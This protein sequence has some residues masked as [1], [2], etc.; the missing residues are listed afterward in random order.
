MNSTS[1]KPALLF[2]FFSKHEL[3][4]AGIF[5]N[6]FPQE[7]HG[8]HQMTADMRDVE[9]GSGHEAGAAAD[10]MDRRRTMKDYTSLW[11]LSQACVTALFTFSCSPP[12]S[13][14]VRKRRRRRNRSWRRWV[15]VTDLT[16]LLLI[17]RRAA[18]TSS[19]TYQER[20]LATRRWTLYL[21][22]LSLLSLFGTLLMTQQW[23]Q[24]QKESDKEC[25]RESKESKQQWE[26]LKREERKSQQEGEK[27]KS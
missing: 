27:E 6:A 7:E 23:G 14:Q 26:G 15:K 12:N 3:F 10:Q 17:R 9:E 8:S 16:H 2:I 4:L 24:T 13:L 19:Q 5:W 11:G 25:R 20:V 22:H 1:S 18:F 21:F